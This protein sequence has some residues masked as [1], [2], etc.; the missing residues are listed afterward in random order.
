MKPRPQAPC[1]EGVEQH[2]VGIARFIA[3][4]FVPQLASG[5]SCG[6]K[7]SQFLSQRFQGGRIEQLDPV[8]ESMFVKERDLILG[9]PI[10][11]PLGS[12]VGTSEEI[13]NRFVDGRK[14]GRHG[15]E[16]KSC[17]S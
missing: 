3:V 5:M 8:D 12:T 10:P 2:P 16:L 17:K 1:A 14:I 13:R 9:Q 4:I 6:K 7:F 11:F 15:I